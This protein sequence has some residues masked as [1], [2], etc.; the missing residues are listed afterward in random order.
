MAFFIEKPPVKSSNWYKTKKYALIL[1]NLGINVYWT[2][3]SVTA[4][5]I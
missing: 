3:A 4:Y 5:S 2:I 1:I